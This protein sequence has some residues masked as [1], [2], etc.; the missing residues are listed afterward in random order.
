MLQALAACPQQTLA[1][2]GLMGEAIEM[3]AAQVMQAVPSDRALVAI[4]GVDGSGKST[5]AS[6]LVEHIHARP[7]I[8]VHVDHFL[9]PSAVRH[10][11]GRNS[12]EGFWLDSYNYSA[13]RSYVLEPLHRGGSGWFR[14]ASY[15]SAKD[16]TTCPAQIYAPPNALVV[17]EGLFLHRDEL[18]DL[19]DMSIFLHVPFCESAR[20]M[21][22]RDGTHPDP[23]HASMRRYVGGQRI[24]FERTRPWER[25]SLVVDNTRFDEPCIV[26]AEQV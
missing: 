20:R 17:V 15:D 26:G 3:I 13:L 19:W 6:N 22:E 8:V 7:T 9:N 12:P 14:T 11:R 16:T 4:D 5:F 18:L 10:A 21:A 2:T 25:A 1:D 23:E 24:Y